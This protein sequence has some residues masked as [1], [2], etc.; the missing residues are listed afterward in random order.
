MMMV[1]T[2]YGLMALAILGSLA[3]WQLT[4]TH[5]NIGETCPMLGP[6]P[7]CIIVALGYFLVTVSAIFAGSK[8]SKRL[9]FIGWL[10]VAFLAASGVA[11]EL[12]GQDICPAGA[13]GIPQCFY[14]LL[15]ALICLA[16]FLSY[17]KFA[18]RDIKSGES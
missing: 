18:R 5:L 15:M 4:Y 12:L 7:A 9:F 14:S 8:W 6:M 17:R 13:L 2:R 10:P 11:L 1:A 16:L 3:G